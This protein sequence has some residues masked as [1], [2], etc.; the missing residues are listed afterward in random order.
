M[1][2]SVNYLT[3]SKGNKIAVQI[4]FS[5]WSKFLDDYKRLK[6]YSKLKTNLKISFR[7]VDEME[8]GRKKPTTLSGFL[9]EC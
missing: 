4:P 8:S 5:Q 6:Q 9:D 1:D 7:E 2:V 3:D